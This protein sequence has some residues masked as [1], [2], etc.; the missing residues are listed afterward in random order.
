MK[1]SIWE[2]SRDNNLSRV[3]LRAFSKINYEYFLS[4]RAIG[5]TPAKSYAPKSPAATLDIWQSRVFVLERGEKV[6]KT[7]YEKKKNGDT[8]MSRGSRGCKRFTRNYIFKMPV[9]TDFWS[10]ADRGMVF[11]Q[12]SRYANRGERAVIF[13]Y[14]ERYDQGSTLA[15]AYC[16][17]GI[18]I[19]T[20]FLIRFPDRKCASFCPQ[21]LHNISKICLNELIFT[22][23]DSIHLKKEYLWEICTIIIQ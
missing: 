23:L 19:C 11:Q 1:I 10:G 18:N 21:N 14:A 12:S 5:T 17:S 2:Y 16:L 6:E 9:R 13:A 7:K 3:L 8:N 20:C 22:T 15:W 4:L